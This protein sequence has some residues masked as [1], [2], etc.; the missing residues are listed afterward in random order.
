MLSFIDRQFKAYG[1]KAHGEEA[2]VRSYADMISFATLSRKAFLYIISA[3]G[4][5]W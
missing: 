3:F 4:L 2:A 5:S 1:I